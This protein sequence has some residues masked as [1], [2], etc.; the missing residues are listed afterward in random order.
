MAKIITDDGEIIDEV[1]REI[2]AREPPRFKTPWNHDTRAESLATATNKMEESRTQQQFLKDADINN[3][4]RK[5][6]QTGELALTGKPTYQNVD[7]ELDL[8]DRIITGDE[9]NTAWNALPTAVRAILKD[10]QQFVAYIEHCMETGDIEPL[11]ELGLAKP[12]QTPPAPRGAG[13]EA[14][15]PSGSKTAPKEPQVPPETPPAPQT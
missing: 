6:L 10:P 13:P 11:R 8:L 12:L 1:T 9:V 4:L 2:I 15:P 3:I 14:E 5:F 7:E